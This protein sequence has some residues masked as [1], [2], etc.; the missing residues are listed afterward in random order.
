MRGQ[1]GRQTTRA[2]TGASQPEWVGA[3]QFAKAPTSSCSARGKWRLNSVSTTWMDIEV[4]MAASPLV[5]SMCP[6]LYL[7][8]GRSCAPLS[9]LRSLA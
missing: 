6:L 5:P 9:N 8:G 2:P 1:A 3:S 4:L 7:C